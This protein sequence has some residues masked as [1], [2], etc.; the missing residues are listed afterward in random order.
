MATAIAGDVRALR[1]YF[2]TAETMRRRSQKMIDKYGPDELMPDHPQ[3]DKFFAYTSLWLSTLWVALDG[4]QQLGIVDDHM[5]EVIADDRMLLLRDF[6][7]VT[8]HFM[9]EY[10]APRHLAFITADDS[11]TWAIDAHYSLNVALVEA[12]NNYE[13]H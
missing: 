4:W 7:N 12:L 10:L 9:R 2:V 5:Q 13:S 3:F 8:F 11:M 1:R 6:R